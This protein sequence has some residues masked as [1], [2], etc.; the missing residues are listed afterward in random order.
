MTIHIL[1]REFW[2]TF[3][4]SIRR[5]RKDARDRKNV[6]RFIFFLLISILYYGRLIWISVLAGGS[7]DKG[8]LFIYCIAAALIFIAAGGIWLSNSLDERKAR[9]ESDRA[10]D[11]SLR[12][13]L[14]IDGFALSV[15]LSRAGSEQLL[16]EKELPAGVQVIT[17]KAHL[18][19]LQKL[20]LWNALPGNVRNLLLM[21]DAHWPGDAIIL[22]LS[23]EALRCLRWVLRV[24]PKLQPLA[25]LPTMSYTFAQQL[26]EKPDRFLAGGMLDAWDIR[27]ERNFADGFFSRCYAEMIGRGITTGVTPETFAWAQKTYEEARDEQVRDLLV[28]HETVSE[29][30]DDML[31]YMVSIS[32]Q[33][34]RCLQII[35][36]LQD[37][38]DRWEDWHAL[39]FPIRE[40]PPQD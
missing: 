5:A 8:T 29:L 37:G 18:E 34:Y 31:R 12:R 23:F 17:R 13:R 3:W 21:P 32:F 9:I 36:D 35:M 19:Q 11:Q 30:N 15:L 1:S 33:R 25:H 28:A 26:L 27:V 39:C 38:V 10:V 2:R 20:D 7:G 4:I 16:R 6:L 14:S 22:P 24:D 40:P